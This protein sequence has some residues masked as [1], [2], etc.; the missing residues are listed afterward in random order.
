MAS[1]GDKG[2][3]IGV[4]DI[5]GKEIANGDRIHVL[6]VR[7]PDTPQESVEA[8]FDARVS[9]HSFKAAFFYTREGVAPEDEDHNS[10]HFNST[11]SRY[12]ILGEVNDR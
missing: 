11:S 10:Y 4:M 7:R 1:A 3:L 6:H 8:E 12:E 9:Y 5:N 2:T